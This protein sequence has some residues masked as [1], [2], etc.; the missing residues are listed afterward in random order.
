V[1]IEELVEAYPTQL[2]VVFKHQPLPFHKNARPAAMASLAAHAQGKFWA[3]H[4][5]LFENRTALG[6]ANL[7]RY[8]KR[9]GLKMKAFN[10]FMASGAGEAQIAAD[11]AVAAKLDARGTPTS[12]INGFRLMGARPAEDFR[13]VID[14]E[15]EKLK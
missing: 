7:K 3:Y 9:V 4:D 12:F 6:S 1:T 2:K 14:K 10:A 8:A 13:V 15:L 5:L 11:Q